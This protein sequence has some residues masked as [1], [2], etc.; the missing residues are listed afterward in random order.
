[1]KNPVL[2]L[3]SLDRLHARLVSQRSPII[4]L[5][6]GGG[7]RWEDLIIGLAVEFR[8]WSAKGFLGSVVGKNIVTLHIFNP[9]HA[10]QMLHEP[11]ETLHAIP[12]RLLHLLP[13]GDISGDSEDVGLAVEYHAS[14]ADFD[15]ERRSSLP[16]VDALEW[17]HPLLLQTIKE[18]LILLLVVDRIDLGRAHREQFFARIAEP[19]PHDIV[20][21]EESRLSIDEEMGVV[22]MIADELESPRLLLGPLPLGDV[23]GNPGDSDD[24]TRLVLDREAPV[25]DPADGPIRRTIRYSSAVACPLACRPKATS[26]RSRS[27]GWT[28]SRNDRGRSLSPNP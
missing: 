14:D 6:L 2:V 9:R 18:S 8:P 25:P 13:L 5:E 11:C 7:L 20:D 16:L 28:A 15:R 24:L 21:V 3:Q 23:L 27:S 19:L 10:G 4:L 17:R 12:Q 22:G 1:M 26:N